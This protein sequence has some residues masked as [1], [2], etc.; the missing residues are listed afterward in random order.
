MPFGLRTVAAARILTTANDE[1]SSLEDS[2]VEVSTRKID[3]KQLDRAIAKVG[4]RGKPIEVV[5]PKGVSSLG[6]NETMVVVLRGS[7]MALVRRT[8]AVG[9]S[10]TDR[11]LRLRFEG[12]EAA[13]DDLTT[14]QSSPTSPQLTPAEAALLDEAGFVEAD[15]DTTSGLERSR[16]EFGIMLS[17]SLS[18]EAAG[19]ALGVSPSRLRQRLGSRTL[20]GVKEAGAWRLPRFQFESRS[21]LVRHIDKV[22]PAIAIDAHPLAVRNW[23]TTPHPDLV[24][25]KGDAERPVTPLQWL[26]AGLAAKT[27]ADLADEI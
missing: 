12:A 23:F 7:R 14:E 13:V 10:V 20:Y 22:L 27:V 11:E 19:Q 15:G 5:L 8:R 4:V 6:E 9:A 16:I 24:V 17:E 18:L 21:K 26:S 3:L 25:G 2:E 1:Y